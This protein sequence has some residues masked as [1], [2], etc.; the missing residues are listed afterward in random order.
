VFNIQKEET[1][2]ERKLSMITETG[3]RRS[4]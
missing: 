3:G 4:N 1:K 2:R